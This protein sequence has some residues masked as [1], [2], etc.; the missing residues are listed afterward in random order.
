MVLCVE[1]LCVE[2][3]LVAP[4]PVVLELAELVPA[5]V[6]SIAG[7]LAV[8]SVVL[9][10]LVVVLESTVAGVVIE[11]V[12]LVVELLSVPLLQAARLPAIAIIANSFFMIEIYRFKIIF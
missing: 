2:S 3:T 10:V 1:S 12:S 7:A 9:M 4:K 5:V 8:V 6:E 11:V